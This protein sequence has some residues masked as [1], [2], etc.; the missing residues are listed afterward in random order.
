MPTSTA[1]GWAAPDRRWA[2]ARKSGPPLKTKERTVKPLL[3]LLGSTIAISAALLGASAPG[4][5]QSYPS[6][7]V[8]LVVGYAQGGTGD[9]IAR[10]I[11][12]KLAQALG[13]PVTIENRP[14]A[15]GAVAAQSVARATPDGYTLLI[16]QPAEIV[17]NPNLVRDVG[18]NPERDFQPIALVAVVPSVLVVQSS[19]PY[20]SV[21][22]LLRAARESPRGLVFA[23]GGPGTPPHLAGEMLRVAS[24][25]KMSHVA[26]EGA[27]PA[28]EALV[29]GRADFAFPAFSTAVPQVKSGKLKMLA[30]SSAR[31]VIA[32]PNVPT[33]EEAGVGPFDLTVWVGVF[34]PHG[35]PEPII[36]R[37]NREINEIVSQPDVREMFVRDGVDVMP[38]SAGQ[39]ESFLQKENTKYKAMLETTFCSR[40]FL[41]GCSGFGLPQVP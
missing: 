35:T 8:Q 26:Y 29:A 12:D 9:I 5:A 6:R 3:K 17:I 22:D 19:A 27:G 24:E 38:M 36:T 1:P 40:F 10:A 14:G 31:R 25:G 18:Y 39:F 23:S 7:A 34:A 21:Q 2:G 32:A 30:V 41:G 13:Q 15:S 20:N 28:L 37:L 4:R 33:I 16:G 11:A